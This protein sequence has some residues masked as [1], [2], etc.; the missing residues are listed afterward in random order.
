MDQG[1]N[2][3]SLSVSIARSVSAC[4]ACAA[5]SACLE[6]PEGAAERDPAF[7]LSIPAQ[8]S[9][10]DWVGPGIVEGLL[11]LFDDETLRSLVDRALRHNLEV[12]LKQKQLEEAGFQTNARWA[13]RLP[14]VTA[15]ATVE[16]SRD[17][18]E[19]AA[20]S[21]SPS[22]NVGWEL[23]IWGKLRDQGAMLEA[24][25][26]ARSEILQVARN[27]VAA[28]VMQGWFDVVAGEMLVALESSRLAN[29]EQIAEDSQARYRSGLT[30]FDDLAAV[31]RDIAETKSSLA[32]SSIDRA[33]AARDLQV[34]LG[35]YPDGIVARG[36][37]LPSVIPAPDA[38][39][40]A[41]LITE[42]PDL[43]AAWHDVVSADHSVNVAHKE[44]YPS[45]SL[46]GSLGRQSADFSQFLTGA[47]VWSLASSLTVPLFNAPRLRNDLKAAQSRADQAWLRY[48]QSALRAFGEVEQALNAET[49][50][51]ERERWLREAERHADAAASVFEERYRTG[52]VSITE[53]LAAQEAAF[54]LRRQHISVRNQRLKNRVS[55]ALALGKGV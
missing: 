20:V 13:G 45:L 24:T 42:R 3:N 43:R 22:L 6:M 46:T 27:T 32:Q 16:R 44:L 34:L 11:D 8:Y 9:E 5:L 29:L 30:S 52:L 54:D 53:H 18:G 41:S 36:R 4:A 38:G 7:A 37:E 17:A 28:Q 26:S 23:D 21:Y 14:Y 39:L 55:L 35:S 12:R 47:T 25:V 33:A 1:E 49:L 2:R 50:L 15:D 31:Q 10:I 19:D 48:L 51:A 40:P